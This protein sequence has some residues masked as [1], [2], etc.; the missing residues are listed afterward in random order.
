MSDWKIVGKPALIVLHMQYAIC[1]P[2]G[3]VAH[4]GHAKATPRVGN[5]SKSAGAAQGVSRAQASRH[6]R[7]C[8]DGTPARPPRRR[9][10]VA[11]GPP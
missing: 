9:F 2:G 1:D 7:Q 3:R 10:S 6:L 11:S 5:S 4:V 8:G